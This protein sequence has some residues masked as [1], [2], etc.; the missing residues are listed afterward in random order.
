MGD[1]VE[2]MKASL[3]AGQIKEFAFDQVLEWEAG[4]G[5]ETIDGQ[6][7]QTGIASYKAETVFGIKSLK[8]KA[9]MHNGKVVRWLHTKTGMEIK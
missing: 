8:A 7:Y 3:K 5:M 2:M 9:L 6:S 4:E 1:P